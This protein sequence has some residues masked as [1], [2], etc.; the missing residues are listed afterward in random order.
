MSS[1][2]SYSKEQMIGLAI[3]F[4]VLPT[5][6]Y[7]LRVWAR[8]LINRVTLDDYLSGAALVSWPA[9][10]LDWRCVL[11]LMTVSTDFF[12]RLLLVAVIR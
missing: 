10:A 1:D 6:F 11:G 4:M 5:V 12:D 3:G 7:A 8:I 2:Y 9:E